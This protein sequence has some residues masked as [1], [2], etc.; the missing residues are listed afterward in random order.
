MTTQMMSLHAFAI[1]FAYISKSVHDVS[2]LTPALPLP[3]DKKL[4]FWWRILHVLIDTNFIIKI[5]TNNKAD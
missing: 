4:I 1:T 5:I 3:S 2:E